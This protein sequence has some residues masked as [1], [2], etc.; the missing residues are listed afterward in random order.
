MGQNTSLLMKIAFVLTGLTVIS[1]DWTLFQARLV[2]FCVQGFKDSLNSKHIRS[3]PLVGPNFKLVS[4][5]K[6]Y[7]CSC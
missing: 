1:G 2:H 6:P 3:S 7:F 5:I 4:N